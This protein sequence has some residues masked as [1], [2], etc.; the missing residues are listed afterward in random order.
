MVGALFEGI[1]VSLGSFVGGIMYDVYGGQLT[2]RLYGIGAIVAC[3]LHA[4]VQ[5]FLNR[6]EEKGKNER[7]ITGDL[8]ETKSR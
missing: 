8:E 2:F 3:F 5:Y 4:G 7:M 1:G 6:F